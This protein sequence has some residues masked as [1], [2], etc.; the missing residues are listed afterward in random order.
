MQLAKAIKQYHERLQ[1]LAQQGVTHEMAVRDAFKNLLETVAKQ[2]KW[3]LVL[4]QRM[5][6]VRKVVRPDGTLRDINGLPRGYWEAKDTKDDLQ[7]EVQKKF[8]K[9]YPNRNIIFEDTRIALLYQNGELVYSADLRRVNEIEQLF[10]LFTNFTEKDIEGFNEAVAH[11]QQQT[12]ELAKGLK[13]KIEAA[14]KHNKPFQK[15]FQIFW[16]L[17]KEAL[18]P[19]IS[20]AAINEMLIQHL[21]T[22]RVLRTVFNLSDFSQRNPIASEV[23]KVILALT[24]QN[25]SRK[26]FLGQLDYFYTA[27]EKAAATI[28]D[29]S[30]KQYFL[31][32]VYERFFQGY[33]VKIADTH[34]IVYTPQPIVEF[35]GAAVEELLEREFGYTL[36]DPDVQIIDPCTGTGNFIVHLLRRIYATAPHEL[37]EVYQNR[38]FANEVLLMPYYIAALNIEHTYRELTGQY[39]PFEGLCLVDTL[40]LAER[41]QQTLDIFAPKNTARVLRQKDAPITVIIGNPPYNVGQQSENDNNK[42]RRYPV[43][44]NN[45]RQSYAKDSKATLK[46]QLY[47]AYVRFFRWATDRLEGRDGIVCFVSNNSFIDSITFDGMRKHLAQDFQQIYIIDL[48]GNVRQ[49]SMREGIPIGPQHTVFGLAAMV[50]ISITILVKKANTPA[51]IYYTTVDWKAK[52]EEKFA[53]LAQSKTLSG[54]NL[55]ELHP[56]TKS[57]WLTGEHDV[58]FAQFLPIGTKDRKMRRKGHEET[59]FNTYSSGIKTNRD[60]TLYSFDQRQLLTRMAHFVENYNSEIDRYKRA[61]EPKPDIDDFVNYSLMKWDGTLK[62]HLKKLNYGTFASQHCRSSLYRPFTRRFLYFDRLLINSVYLQHSFFPTPIAEQENRMICVT[63]HSQIPFSVQ[64]TKQIPCLDVGGRPTQCFPFYTYKADGSDRRENITDWALAHFQQNYQDSTIDKWEIFYYLYGLLHHPEYRTRYASN[65]KRELPRL[66]LAP[67]FREIAKI[68]RILADLHLNYEQ[69]KPYPLKYQLTEGQKLDWRVE[70]MRLSADKTS[71][72]VN[73]SLSLNGIP[74]E[75]FAYRLGN[76]S[77]LEWVIDQYQVKGEPDSPFYSDPNAYGAS[78]GFP[79]PE[80]YVVELVQRVVTVTLETIKL[81]EQLGD[82][83]II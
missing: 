9:G 53:F 66:P 48:K 1:S 14:H 13:E 45:I 38:L 47:D 50:G 24:S 54:I 68:G 19:N 42:N 3:E 40:D 37:E 20:Q 23:E 49:D 65:L 11:F 28:T 81:V 59:I 44:D 55:R 21:L 16:T 79:R 22:E 80:R 64:L 5:E 76:R 2:M 71:L 51:K 72:Q 15:A 17:C 35:M 36:A 46:N 25:F 60:D 52:R 27:I 57:T 7:A 83:P 26:E 69:L 31:N 41:V 56:D 39:E 43:L 82:R 12:P 73:E 18:N 10:H 74:P 58:E 6:G 4:E 8:A 75:A 33:A 32:T 77:A 34:G 62:G 70:K 30:D 63:T 29:F 78:A 61:G 67:D